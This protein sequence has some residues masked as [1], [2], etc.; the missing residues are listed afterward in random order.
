MGRREREGTGTI[1]I[2]TYPADHVN[3][4]SGIH[5]KE[6]PDDFCSDLGLEV[7]K[8]V[9]YPH[10]LRSNP[11]VGLVALQGDRVCGF[12]AVAAASGFYTALVRGY[13]IRTLRY[14]IGALIRRP[15]F[16]RYIASVMALLF[17]K[18]SYQPEQTD[19]ELLYEAV[20][21]ESQGLSIGSELIRRLFEQ[22][23]DLNGY[24]RC[25]VKTL[26]STPQTNRFYEKNGFEPL[27]RAFGRVW[28]AR[29]I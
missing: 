1:S 29:K 7:L 4:V 14:A 26:E 10:F 20:S 16:L 22:V 17:S 12:V 8:R 3:Q 15:S 19:V 9:Y 5:Y 18:Q 25:V 27:R 24:D 6:L 21:A 2:E 23:H 13:P 11:R 28:H